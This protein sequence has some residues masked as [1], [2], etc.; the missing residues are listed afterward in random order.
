VTDRQNAN[1]G[2][3]AKPEKGAPWERTGGTRPIYLRA[4]GEEK[5]DEYGLQKNRSLAVFLKIPLGKG[6]NQ[7]I[8][9]CTPP[10]KNCKYRGD[11]ERGSN[12]L[13]ETRKGSFG[14]SSRKR[15][16]LLGKN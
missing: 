4:R 12:T 3:K 5:K 13:P 11:P 9:G 1:N 16:R 15:K 14:R 7:T 10:T 6:K 2:I 8:Q